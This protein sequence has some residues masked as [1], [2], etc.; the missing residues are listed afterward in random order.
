MER[1]L[2]HAAFWG[3][4]LAFWLGVVSEALTTCFVTVVCA[5]AGSFVADA[6]VIV[7]FASMLRSSVRA[8]KRFKSTI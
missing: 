2:R 6:V 3:A 5:P 4:A 1:L 7:F 8:V